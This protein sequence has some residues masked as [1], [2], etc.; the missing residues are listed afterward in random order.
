MDLLT[1]IVC[2]CDCSM[3][4]L[5]LYIDDLCGANWKTSKELIPVSLHTITVS[6]DSIFTK[7]LEA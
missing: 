5:Q 4:E 6:D 3:E 1:L 7:E 2:L